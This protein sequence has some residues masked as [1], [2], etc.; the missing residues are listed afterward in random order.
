MVNGKKLANSNKS[1]ICNCARVNQIFFSL[2][3]KH[4]SLILIGWQRFSKYKTGIFK[5]A[6]YNQSYNQYYLTVFIT[7]IK[8]IFTCGYTLSLEEYINE[9]FLIV[10]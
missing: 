6:T 8:A 1:K 5:L 2:I 9:D 3:N 7:A 10:K 4:E